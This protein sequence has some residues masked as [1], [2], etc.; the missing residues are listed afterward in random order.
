M[1]CINDFVSGTCTQ[2]AEISI[3]LVD[4]G[5]SATLPRTPEWDANLGFNYSANVDG[6]EPLVRFDWHYV[7][8]HTFERVTR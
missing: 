8:D 7:D 5:V 6:G 2:T 4:V 3:G 1:D